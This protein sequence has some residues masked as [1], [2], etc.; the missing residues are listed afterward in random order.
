[1]EGTD[2]RQARTVL[3]VARELGVERGHHGQVLLGG[4]ETGIR[5]LRARRGD[6]P[7]QSF[8]AVRIQRQ[9]EVILPQNEVA[10]GDLVHGL[11]EPD[12]P[13]DR[14]VAGSTTHPLGP[15]YPR[16]CVLPYTGTER[17][18]TIGRATCRERVWQYG[19]I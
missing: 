6:V 13:A 16:Q 5:Q 11:V 2:V 7:G 17:Q 3:P 14:L 8:L 19:E 18:R 10:A 12:D 9:V 15:V 4:D 1:M